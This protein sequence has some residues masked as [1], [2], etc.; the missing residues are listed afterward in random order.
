MPTFSNPDA[1]SACPR[2]AAHLES[3]RAREPSWHARPVPAFGGLDA[4][5]LVV[6]LGPGERGAN[7]TGRPFTGDVAGE[8]LYPALHRFGFA[9]TAEP[10]GADGWANSA[11]HLTDCRITNAVRCLPPANKP[12]PA[13]IRQCNP[14]LAAEIGAM[15]RLR[16]VVALGTVAHA[17]VLRA[18]GLRPS[19]RRFGHDVRHE[20]PGGLLLVDS[21]HCSGYNWRTGRLSRDSF[22]AVFAGVRQFLDA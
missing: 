9:S 1:C 22:E 14:H 3:I 12:S 6:G 2:L 8:L 4:R 13:E 11:M 16:V 18:C 15:A 5:L 10:L 7:R 19:A 21:Y 20:L 17:A